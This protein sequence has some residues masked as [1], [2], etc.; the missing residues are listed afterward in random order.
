MSFDI[1]VLVRA[2]SW[3]TAR[4]FDDSLVAASYPLRLGP[5]SDEAWDAPL[6][7]V[8][9]K[10]IA[11]SLE[12]AQ[13]LG[14]P[15]GA[16]LEWSYD[17]GMPIVLDGIELDP[18][19]GIEVVS[20]AEE[21]NSTLRK[22]EGSPVAETGDYLMWFS[23]HVDQRHWNGAVYVLAAMILQFSGF[24]FELQGMSGGREPFANEL[25]DTLYSDPVENP[26]AFGED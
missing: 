6:A 26:F 3:P 18:D 17:V 25:F 13:A 14:R 23:H 2:N 22:F 10:P 8:P 15:V 9:A 5:R 11:I 16:P 1:Y 7:P 12:Q 4:Q 24:A 19:F 21:L 20:D